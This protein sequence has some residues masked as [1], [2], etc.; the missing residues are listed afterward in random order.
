MGSKI[1]ERFPANGRLLTEAEK[2]QVAKFNEKYKSLNKAMNQCDGCRSG[3]EVN[4][5]NVHVDPVGRNHIGCTKH[6][7][8]G[9]KEYHLVYDYTEELKEELSKEYHPDCCHNPDYCGQ[10]YNEQCPPSSLSQL[11]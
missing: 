5:Y 1:E 8:K 11:R 3:W 9:P 2:V 4:K 7:Y 10:K 6:L